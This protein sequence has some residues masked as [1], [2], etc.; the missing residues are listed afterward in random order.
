MGMGPLKTRGFV[1]GQ[2]DERAGLLFGGRPSGV[3]PQAA[4]GR[5]EALWVR[6]RERRLGTC[7][8][9]L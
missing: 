7:A 5:R 8:G 9:P 3:L 4:P 6:R 1:P 2:T